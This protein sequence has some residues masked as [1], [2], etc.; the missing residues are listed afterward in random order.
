MAEQSSRQAGFWTAWQER[1]TGCTKEQA[2]S[3]IKELVMRLKQE[4]YSPSREEFVAI[5]T[6]MTGLSLGPG[7]MAFGTGLPTWGVMRLLLKRRGL[8]VPAIVT[9]AAYSMGQLY[10]PAAAVVSLAELSAPLGPEVRALVREQSINPKILRGLPRDL[11]RGPR[12][13]PGPL[14]G[15][16]PEAMDASLLPDWRSGDGDVPAGAEDDE[17]RQSRAWHEH[18][19][20]ADAQDSYGSS[21]GAEASPDMRD[22]PALDLGWDESEA[23]LQTGQNN[24]KDNSL[25]GRR[26]RHVRDPLRARNAEPDAQLDDYFD[27]RW[28]NQGRPR[29]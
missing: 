6:S 19:D 17:A 9:V 22:M 13:I 10:T 18:A 8:A 15:T 2:R 29:S 25:R 16:D 26:Q 28:D 23:D 5:Q 27:H 11:A 1:A 4:G 21:E 7:M 24:P 14:W 12:L 3:V 20:S